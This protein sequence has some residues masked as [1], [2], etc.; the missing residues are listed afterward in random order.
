[1]MAVCIFGFWNATATSGFAII[2]DTTSSGV[3]PTCAVQTNQ[4]FSLGVHISSK[5]SRFDE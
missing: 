3:M 2:F 4:F 5:Q 1:M